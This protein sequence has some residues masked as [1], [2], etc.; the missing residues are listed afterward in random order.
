MV[1][2]GLW[3]GDGVWRTWR[4]AWKGT[5][6][7]RG[8]RAARIEAGEGH[9]VGLRD[10]VRLFLSLW[11]RYTVMVVVRVAAMMVGR[12]AAV[13]HAAAVRLPI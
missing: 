6:M 3:M 1:G 7:V 8:G 9:C 11:Q 5:P 4:L 13:G 10:V 12:A 2:G